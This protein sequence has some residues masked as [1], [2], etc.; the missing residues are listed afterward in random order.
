MNETL[1]SIFLGV[2]LG[3]ITILIENYFWGNKEIKSYEEKY[4][5]SVE[6]KYKG[7]F[8]NKSL[9]KIC[10]NQYNKVLKV[11]NKELKKEGFSDLDIM[12]IHP[13]LIV[14]KKRLEE[15]NPLIF[16]GY[17]EDP[18][19]SKAFIIDYLMKKTGLLKRVYKDVRGVIVIRIPDIKPF[20]LT[21]K[22]KKEMEKI[23]YNMLIH[24]TS[25]FIFYK[26]AKLYGYNPY[27][28]SSEY[29]PILMQYRFGKK[30]NYKNNGYL[31]LVDPLK[32]I[33][34]EFFSFKDAK[35]IY[36]KLTKEK[37]E[38]AIKKYQRLYKNNYY[39]LTY[40][41]IGKN[42]I[43][44]PLDPNPEEYYNAFLARK[45][46]FS[47]I[48]NQ[49]YFYKYPIKY[50]IKHLLKRK[51]DILKNSKRLCLKEFFFNN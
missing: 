2:L 35:K 41:L 47:S 15:N 36:P 9:Y 42:R 30:I 21:R 10:L 34:F 38:K 1:R 19:V 13:K 33:E 24:E 26:I 22:E 3:I 4:I 17:Y 50:T 49:E 23:I 40:Y 25:H 31:E 51:K 39:L 7:S 16:Q 46:L 20:I 11:Y 48:K 12:K 37:Y 5:N 29:T 44:E 6:E 32:N 14:V 28:F 43:K 18:N 27:L 45:D 8:I